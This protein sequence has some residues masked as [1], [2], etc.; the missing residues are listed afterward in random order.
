VND[1]SDQSLLECYKN[2]DNLRITGLEDLILHDFQREF[3]KLRTL[4]PITVEL[5]PTNGYGSAGA[6]L[7]EWLMDGGNGAGTFMGVG[8]FA[9]LEEVIMALHVIR[10]YRPCLDLSM[11]P[12]MC[13]L[14]TEISGI[15]VPSYKPVV[16]HAI[17]E[18]ES[19]IHVDGILKNPMNYEP[20]SPDLVGSKRRI[21][22]G[23]HSGIGSLQHCLNNIGYE[24]PEEAL[25]L[26][27]NE[28]RREAVSLRRAL[29]DSEVLLIA[30]KVRVD[31]ETESISN[32]Y[33]AS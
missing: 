27:L 20:F 31:Y 29:N 21:V 22:I 15:K 8:G 3:Q 24:L 12:R 33:H 1:V 4:V 19:G 11:L 14:F 18:V 2:S 25:P 28:V 5:C 10:Q 23:K 13:Q 26:L 32:G 7:T 30:E 9:P 6:V 16:G 17:F